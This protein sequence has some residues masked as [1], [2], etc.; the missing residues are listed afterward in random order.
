MAIS[1]PFDSTLTQDGN[2]NPVYSR[3][4]SSDVLARFLAKYFRNGVFSDD[5]TG[6]QVVAAT[7]MTVKVR[8]GFANINGRQV[9]EE[10]ERVLTV[11][12]AD[13]SLDRIDSVVLRLNLLPSALSIDLYI[14]KGTATVSPSAPALTRNA[15]TWELGLANLFVARNSAT[16]T[17]ERITDTRLDNARCGVVSAVVGSIDT[18]TFYAQ[19][20]A[21]L[22]AFKSG[23]EA[24]FDSWFQTVRNTL[25]TDAAGNLLN[26][27]RQL[28]AEKQDLLSTA[29]PL[30]VDKGGTGTGVKGAALVNLGASRLAVAGSATGSF[31][32]I[33]PAGSVSASASLSAL[34]LVAITNG[35]Q[36][37]NRVGFCTLMTAY[38]QGRSC[39]ISVLNDSLTVCAGLASPSANDTLVIVRWMV[40]YL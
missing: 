40:L 33:I 32:I 18:T 16:V 21:D 38:P 9:Y 12:A 11:Q 29:N 25:G 19:I 6:F 23:R 26:Q 27:I 36:T 14:V 22:A 37:Q 3:A 24:S 20:N 30:G 4:Y 35:P 2:G 31:N 13:S 1:W 34:D 10:A 39:S 5:A 28:D 15:S 17:Q 7:G 8:P